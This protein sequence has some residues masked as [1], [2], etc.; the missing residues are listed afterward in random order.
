M[1]ASS[2]GRAYQRGKTPLYS[3][4]RR[5]GGPQSWSGHRG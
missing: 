1:P 4:D 2:P 5:L 3:V